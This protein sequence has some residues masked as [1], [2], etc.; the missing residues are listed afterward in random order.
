ML[1]FDAVTKMTNFSVVLLKLSSVKK[2]M[3][4]STKNRQSK[5]AE[6]AKA[7]KQDA[8]MGKRYF[9]IQQEENLQTILLLETFNVT[10]LFL[11]FSSRR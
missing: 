3:K 1:I 7:L 5:E 10:Q 6:N 9:M 8:K 11:I 2:L 4:S